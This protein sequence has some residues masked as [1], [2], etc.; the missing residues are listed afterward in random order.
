M[1]ENTTKHD[2]EITWSD[3]EMSLATEIISEIKAETRKWFS[4]WLITAALL[5]ISNLLW[6]V[7]YNM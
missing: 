5:V 6:Y 3:V 2:N 4:A 1:Q 7:A